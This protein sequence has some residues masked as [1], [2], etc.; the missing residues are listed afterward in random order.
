MLG[1]GWSEGPGRSDGSEGSDVVSSEDAPDLDVGVGCP[2]EAEIPGVGD[3]IEF[4]VVARKSDADD[5]AIGGSWVPSKKGTQLSHSGS[6]ALT[7]GGTA[8]FGL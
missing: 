5:K 8:R 3:C 2:A 7:C 1:R 6:S 4:A